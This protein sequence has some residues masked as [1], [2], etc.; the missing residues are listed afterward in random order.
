M[1][2]VDDAG[3][4]W[5]D[6]RVRVRIHSRQ[7][8]GLTVRIV[9]HEN[10][11]ASIDWNDIAGPGRGRPR[12]DDFPVGAEVEAVIRN[13]LGGPEPPR[14]YCLMIPETL[15]A[16]SALTRGGPQTPDLS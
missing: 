16:S 8:Y 12:P 4:L 2:E 14:W 5:A 6:Q 13:Q 9:G 15:S 1:D 11:P 3:G 10:V 7:H